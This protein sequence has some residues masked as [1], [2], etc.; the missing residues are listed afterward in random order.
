MP[1]RLGELLGRYRLESELG[2]G[3]MAVVYLGTDTTLGRQVAVKV[4]H[5]HL[6]RKEESRRR[7][8]RE[9]T[10]VA[11]L[12]HPNIL[13]VYDFSGPD[14]PEGY[15]VTEHIKGRTLRA[16]VQD[17][18]FQPPE[19]GALCAHELASALAHA[20]GA[21]VVHRDLKPDNVMVR[22]DGVLKLMD[23]GIAKILDRDDKMTVTGAL[24]GSPAHMAPEII[25]GHEAG[26]ASDIFSL[27]TML[28][29][30]AT[31]TLPFEAPNTT[32]T[33]HRILECQYEDPRQVQ[34]A[35][36]DTLAGIITRCLQRDPAARY[37]DAGAL[38]GALAEYLG[39]LGLDRPSEE[40]AAFFLDPAGYRVA[41]RE[42]LCS[43]LAT[44]A[45]TALAGGEMARALSALNQL[46]GLEPAHARAL[47]LLDSMNRARDRDRTLK[48]WARWGGALAG[49]VALAG[50]VG[51]WVTRPT[52]GNTVAASAQAAP[53]TA[54]T[55]PSTA[56]AAPATADVRVA[57]ATARLE[58]RMNALRLKTSPE[59]RP[60]VGQVPVPGTG[61]RPAVVPAGGPPS[62]PVHFTVQVRPFGTVQLDRGPVS[63]EALARHELEALPGPHE[64]RVSCPDLCDEVVHK[65]EV[66]AVPGQVHLLGARARAA[67]L[68]FDFQPRDAQVTV[69]GERRSAAESLASPFVVSGAVGPRKLEHEVA[70]EISRPGYVT[71]QG[72]AVLRPGE[73]RVLSGN[74]VADGVTANGGG[75]S[76]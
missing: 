26:P 62:S 31:G 73:P 64:V 47:S 72:V 5:P 42:R 18:A 51:L 70:W 50:A 14:A 65:L 59:N 23:F 27:G 43:A 58:A 68:S 39:A 69:L 52:P 66:G 33:L 25:E 46:L 28:Y 45:E 75:Q 74:L 13:E 44:R 37:P 20:H 30:L 40:L 24:V 6:S 55:A 49:G 61:L 15:L 9:A 35:V 32:A 54:P 1:S 4:L 16:W 19:L 8:A 3:G 41:C 71:Q 34:P 29:L 17:G 48:R 53:S 11:R 56:Q 22:E 57:P 63:T 2:S 12:H 36:S 67:K 38:R 10:A 76:R 21:G 7:F 60:D